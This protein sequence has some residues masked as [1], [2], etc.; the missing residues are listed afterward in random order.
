MINWNYDANDYS[1]NKTNLLDEG[2][3]RVRIIN[4]IETVA[5]NGTEGL[6]ISLEHEGTPTQ[7]GIFYDNVAH[8][9]RE[10]LNRTIDNIR[11]I[12]GKHA[13]IPAVIL[14]EKKMPRG[15]RED[16]IMPSYIYQ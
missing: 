6:E 10:R 16:I 1:A 8:E 14:D 7:L 2:K 12:Y 15:M 13:I 4:A 5:K 11:D 3:Y 9:K